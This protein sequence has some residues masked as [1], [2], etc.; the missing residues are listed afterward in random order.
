M[1]TKRLHVF[2]AG[3]QTSAQGVEREFTPKDLD[4]VVRSYD[5]NTHEAPLVIGHSGD[6]DSAPSYGWIKQFVRKGDDLYADVNFTDVAKDLVKDGHYRKVSISFYSPSSP[7]NPH[8]GQWSARHLALLG[9]S[10]PAVKGLEPFS[11]SEKE[12]VFDY[13]TALTPENIFDTDLGPTMI[14]EKS[15]LELLKE[16]LDEIRGEISDS[17]KDLE[18]NQA[19]QSQVDVGQDEAAPAPEMATQQFA[20]LKRKVSEASQKLANL[21]TMMPSDSYEEG[22]KRVKAQGAHGHN[23]QVVE[24][25]FEEKGGKRVKKT[26]PEEILEIAEEVED[27]FA[28]D[29]VTRKTSKGAHGQEVQVVEQVH[30][31]KAH[32]KDKMEVSEEEVME[33]FEEGITR[34]VSKGAHGQEVQ[35][36]EQ[37][38][39]EMGKKKKSH[40][41]IIVEEDEEDMEEFKEDG[42]VPAGMSLEGE[43]VAEEA[44]ADKKKSSKKSSMMGDDMDEEEEGDE[45]KEGKMGHKGKKS[46]SPVEDDDYLSEEDDEMFTE[47]AGDK[48]VKEGKAK[49]GHHAE[50]DLSNPAGRGSTGRSED[51]SY[52]ARQSVGKGEADGREMT[53]DDSGEQ[54][55]K[56]VKTSKSNEQD[57][58]REKL[59][60]ASPQENTDAESRWA[61][62]NG[63]E[64]VMNADQYDIG[65]KGLPERSKPGTSD[66]NEPHGRDGGPTKVSTLMEEDPSN[67]EFVVDLK[68]TKGN[69]TARV[70]H[71]ES[72]DKRAPLKGG[73]IPDH[74]DEVSHAEGVGHKTTK[75]GKVSFGTHP[76]RGGDATGRGEKGKGKD[77]MDSRHS[78]AKAHAEDREGV[79]DDN[80]EQ[81][82]DRVKTAKH[83]EQEA[84][85]VKTAKADADDRWEDQPGGASR[86]MNNDQ[87]DDSD[88]GIPEA[89]K[90]G[91]SDGDEP[92]GRDGGPTKV[93]TMMEEDPSNEEI[94]T[95][96]KN[97]KQSGDVRVV[98]QKAGEKRA[99]VKGQKIQNEA[100]EADY[101]EGEADGL[102]REPA[103]AKV[104][105][106]K[107]PMGRHNGPTE[108]PD[109]S[110][111]DPD[112]LEMAVDLEDATQSKKV[113]IVRQKSG[114]APTLDHKEKA[115]TPMT[116]TGKGST[117][118]QKT[119]VLMDEDEVEEGYRETED[120]GM[121]SLGQ[122][123]AM[124]YPTAMFEELKALKEE[125]DRLKKEYEGQKIRA[126]KAKIAEFVENLYIEGKLTDGVIPQSKLQNYCEGLEFG[127]LEF[128]EGESATTTLFSILERL[129]NMVY[130]GEVV[131]NTKF[132][133]PEDDDLDPHEKAMRMVANGEASDYVEAIKRC[134]PWGANG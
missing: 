76:E 132:Q 108:F 90:P 61:E 21:E 44:P 18:K 51:D 58:S 9:A 97:V 53:S 115:R 2:K 72:G 71:Q 87:F 49:F 85:R 17:L 32:K 110:E 30:K 121:G 107:D 19:S 133:D 22:V 84:D 66:G 56:R 42:K 112:N 117:Y 45:F 131:A 57:E 14:Q 69:K 92:H 126:R 54:D 118:G 27:Q 10:P 128:A 101:A 68:S 123:K 35:V 1:F 62:Q 15:P 34:K 80:G 63:K 60:K 67:E 93:S 12:G 36:V 129:P 111:E 7:I 114:D 113:R 28:E 124:G 23:V 46:K 43:E 70:L 3:A 116:K 29:G 77:D 81:D 8:K 13:A 109:K 83:S 38:Y 86:A 130:F 5:P 64:R 40:K 104:S 88:E 122:A 100:K 82:A 120:F 16:R 102:T 31:E 11:F 119:P 91:I 78:V 89:N 125:N 99:A 50:K 26:S 73:E 24:E 127:T 103:P 94:V 37:V 47:G 96:L 25:V 95:P 41:P 52:A 79:I 98:Y 75:D 55:A 65:E 59:A 48:S 106:K 20:E 74:A 105:R 6:N 39:E 33:E 4:E 134:I